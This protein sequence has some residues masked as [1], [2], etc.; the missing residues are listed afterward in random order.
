MGVLTA[1]VLAA[2]MQAADIQIGVGDAER[3][4]HADPAAK[5]VLLPGTNHVL[6]VV[7]SSDRAEN[8]ATY[9]DPDLPLA[10]GVVY[11][12]SDFVGAAR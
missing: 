4:V 8:M 5:L 10:P 1:V 12:I 11:A 3:L 7:T 9:S 6:K 2:A